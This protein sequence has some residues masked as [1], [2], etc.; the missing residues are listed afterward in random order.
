MPPEHTLRIVSFNVNGLRAILRRQYGPTA[1]IKHFL[2]DVGRDADIVCLQETKLREQELQSAHN[3]AVAEGWE[4]FFACSSS[5]RGYSGTATFVRSSLCMPFDASI[6]FTASGNS[7]ST[8]SSCPDP[9]P[10]P[11]LLAGNEF[12]VDELRS[13]DSEGRVVVTDHGHFVLFNVYGPAIT[14]EDADVAKSRMVF[15]MRF[16]SALE[17]RWR[18]I[19]AANRAVV[20][21]GDLNIAPGQIDYPDIDRDFYR[22]SRPDRRWLHAL[23][24][25]NSTPMLQQNDETSSDRLFTDCF[26]KFFPDRRAAFTVWSTA[27]GARANNYGSR[28]DLTLSSGLPFSRPQGGVPGLDVPWVHAA[29]IEPQI[30]GSDH[31]PVWVQLGKGSSFLCAPNPPKC[32][33]RFIL[34]GKQSNLLQWLGS[35]Q[36][37]QE[38]HA[39]NTEYGNSS[40]SDYDDAIGSSKGA[41]HVKQPLPRQASLFSFIE[42]STETALGRKNVVDKDA[43]ISVNKWSSQG[44]QLEMKARM[45]PSFME[46]ELVAAASIEKE[47]LEN[48]KNAWQK[49]HARMQVPRCL[50][51]E[52]AALKRVNKSGVNHGE[53]NFTEL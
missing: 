28:I 14:S 5:K 13:L 37:Q 4:S 43:S 33:M 23:L 29:D 36:R 51:G 9:Y 49:I 41:Q 27:T 52:L 53:R 22:P 48:A 24:H 39:R 34:S 46:S 8:P 3:L 20:V 1:T 21:V 47:Q 26:R 12:T 15:K 16:Y 2:A 38:K 44:A 40:L 10:Y 50:H 11:E 32:S 18:A 35:C 7:H 45:V 25:G 42:S 6:G 17:R 31:C 19:R 30:L